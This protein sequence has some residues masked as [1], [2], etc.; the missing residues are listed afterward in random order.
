MKFAGRAAKAVKRCRRWVR[1][2]VPRRLWITLVVAVLLLG[3]GTVGYRWI[4]GE[5]WSYF[6]GFYMTAITLTT[7]GYGETHELSRDGRLFTVILAYS[8]IFTLAYFASELVRAVV[9]GELKQV[10][11]RQWVDDQLANLTGHT[12]VCGYGR[13]GRIVCAELER[14]NKWFV[15]VDRSTDRL[16]DF[17]FAHGLPLV[18]DGTADDIL[19]KAGI[20]RAKS[21]ISVVG[22]DADNLYICLSARLLAP[23]LLI[24]ARAE[25]EEAETKLRKVGANKVIS[26][27]LAGGHRAVQA[28]LR[29]TVLHFMEMA[30]RP[31]FMDLQIEEVRVAPGCKLDGQTLR[32]SRVHPDLGIVVVGVLRPGGELVYNPQGDMKIEPEAVL[33]ALGQRKHLDQLERLAGQRE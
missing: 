26:P 10:I 9:T 8:G 5:K 25:E 24:V 16:G 23:K 18:G 11:G 3:T 31:E 30:T 19:R 22:S 2:R 6:D 15:V 13:M 20:E 17:P 12:V 21:L 28:V 32:Q 7:I 14:Q 27:Y 1:T 4:E 29:P 33:I